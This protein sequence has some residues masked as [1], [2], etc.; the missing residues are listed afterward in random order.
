MV[1]LMAV[2]L[3]A[4]LDAWRV[5]LLAVEKVEPKVEHWAASM[6]GTTDANSAVVSVAVKVEKMDVWTVVWMAVLMDVN[7]VVCSA[8]YSVKYLVALLVALWVA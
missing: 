8:A 3:A 4:L 1:V 6:V 2:S 5:V 7:S